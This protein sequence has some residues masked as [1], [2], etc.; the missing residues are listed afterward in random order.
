MKKCIIL[1][2]LKHVPCSH[3]K[4]TSFE[5]SDRVWLGF[6]LGPHSSRLEAIDQA[7]IFWLMW[8][9]G[10]NFL[11]IVKRYFFPYVKLLFVNPLKNFNN[12]NHLSKATIT[13]KFLR[14]RFFL[15]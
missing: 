4:Y 11:Y 9:C 13:E 8:V 2:K 3:Q 10:M 1:L 12:K 14:T 15:V 6:D 7:Y 5:R